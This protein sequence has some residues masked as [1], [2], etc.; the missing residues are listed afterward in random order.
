M[1]WSAFWAWALVGA[2]LCLGVL[3]L[4]SIGLL[5]IAAGL[6]TAGFVGRRWPAGGN[7]AGLVAGAGVAALV[8]A[9]V[10][11][12]AQPSCAASYGSCDEFDIRPWLAAG[13]ALL[14]G[15]PLVFARLRRS[16]SLSGRW[17]APPGRR[18]RPR[19]SAR[20]RARGRRTG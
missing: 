8:V 20:G 19:R 9:F 17:R 5:L 16:A 2:L 1:R 13:A 15:A 14:A 3:A 6:A 10:N 11:R 12:H 7:A 18:G 4:L